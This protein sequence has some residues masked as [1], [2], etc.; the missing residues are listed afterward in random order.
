MMSIH[1]VLIGLLL[2]AP[3]T[4]G[5]T[6]ITIPTGTMLDVRMEEALHSDKT[7]EGDTFKATLLEPVYADA[8][9]ILSSGGT[10]DG[11]VTSV[12]SRRDGNASSVLGLRLTKL[13]TL[14]GQTYDIHGA[15]VG[16]RK[17]LTAVEPVTLTKDE[18]KKAVIV[19]GKEGEG[20]GDRSSSVVGLSGESEKDLAARWAL[21]GLSHDFVTIDTGSEITFELRDDIKVQ[22]IPAP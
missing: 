21:S 18:G 8:R 19:I 16:F 1:R 14:Q 13:H 7:R 5:A 4:A 10:V 2:A 11:V 15:M 22:A 9:V 12:K 6:D 20:A 3:I 17:H